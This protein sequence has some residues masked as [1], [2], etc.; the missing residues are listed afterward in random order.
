[1]LE[2]VLNGDPTNADYDIQPNIVFSNS[3]IEYVFRFTRRAESVVDTNQTFL[4]STDLKTWNSI[5]LTGDIGPEV[6]IG[7][8]LGDTQRLDVKLETTGLEEGGKVFGKLEVA[9]K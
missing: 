7:N 5:N 6:A 8:I 1:M 3:A 4:Y 2:Y 9:P